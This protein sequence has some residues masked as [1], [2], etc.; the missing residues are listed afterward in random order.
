MDRLKIFRL[1][2]GLFIVPLFLLATYGCGPGFPIVTEEQQDYMD[3]VDRT[4]KKT[5]V[6]EKRLDALESRGADKEGVEALKLSLA[7]TTRSVED[8]TR[9][10]SFVRGSLEESANARAQIES[11]ISSIEEELRGIK[12]EIRAIGEAATSDHD[13]LM[14]LKSSTAAA[15]TQISVLESEIGIL[16]ETLKKSIEAGIAEVAPGAVSPPPLS[17]P[18]SGLTPQAPASEGSA[19]ASSA[20]AGKRQGG[21]VAKESGAA[22]VKTAKA[23]P[24]PTPATTKQE[25]KPSDPEALYFRGF[26]LTKDKKYDQASATFRRFLKLYPHNRLA[27]HARYWLGEIYYTRGDWER[28]I[29]EFDRVIKEY[30]GGDKVPAAILKE[31]FSFDKLGSKKEARLLLEK[32]IEKYPHSPEAG[33]AR[34]RLKKLK[35]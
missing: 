19:P 12:E 2:R 16:K 15:M 8:L 24:Q 5:D 23:G 7:E 32:L 11:E 33:K 14:T 9:E 31:G 35:K 21:E 25:T 26:K 1:A 13:E 17:G 20:V 28:A 29:L 10:F 27:D 6:L 3:K 30:P 4:A 18:G 34:E 22:G